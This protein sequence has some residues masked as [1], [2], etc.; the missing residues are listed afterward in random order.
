M[1]PEG[2]DEKLLI[3]Y[4]PGELSEEEQVQVEDRAF[5]DKHCLDELQ[6][7]EADLIDAYVRGDLPQSARCTFERRFLTSPQRRR[8]LEFARDLARVAAESKAAGTLFPIPFGDTRS[9]INIIRGLDARASV[10]SQLCGYRTN[11][12]SIVAGCGEPRNAVACCQLGS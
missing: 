7:A 4:F 10:R 5:A 1:Q 6:A 11:C 9:L 8:K 12:G 3:K 2:I